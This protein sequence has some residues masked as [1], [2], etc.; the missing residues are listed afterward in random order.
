MLLPGT[1][2]GATVVDCGNASIGGLRTKVL[3]HRTSRLQ[4]CK[5]INGAQT[6]KQLLTPGW[7][8][9][10]PASPGHTGPVRFGFMGLAG[11]DEMRSLP[12]D[13]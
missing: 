2:A 13:R 6:T 9:D 1:Q 3:W 12:S 11:E 8:G 4:D 7:E 10:G 5:Q